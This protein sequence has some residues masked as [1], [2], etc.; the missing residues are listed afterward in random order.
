M[1]AHKFVHGLDYYGAFAGHKRRFE[2]DITD[3]TDFFSNC[4]F[5]NSNLGKLFHMDEYSYNQM[6]IQTGMGKEN[7]SERAYKPKITIAGGKNNVVDDALPITF[8]TI[9]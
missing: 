9:D 5:F 2:V 3:D 4:S 1:H 7:A 6:A 8:Y